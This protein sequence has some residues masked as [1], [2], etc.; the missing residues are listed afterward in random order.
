MFGAGLVLLA[1]AYQL[2]LQQRIIED[3][4]RRQ[5]GTWLREQ[6]QSPADT[7][8]LEP[9]GYIGFFSGLKMLDYP[10]LCSPEVVAARK[11]ASS[12]SY[13]F[14]WSEL[15]M[16][17]HPRWLVLRPYEATAIREREPLILERHYELARRFDV[18]EKVAAISFLPGRG[19]L[20]NDAVFEVYRRRDGWP[21]EA[22]LTPIG[23]RVLTRN[24]SWTGPAYDSGDNLAVHAPSVVEFVKPNRANSLSGGFGIFEG[25]YTE[26]IP[27]TDG[28]VFQV[29]FIDGQGKSQ[30]LFERTINPRT[31]PED[32]GLQPLRVELPEG[33]D[34]RIELSI[35]TGEAGNHEFDWTYWSR[36]ALETPRR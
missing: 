9:L 26:H 25:A 22:I 27:G 32:R 4:H 12:P 30:L 11:R 34:G 7:V 13:P 31:T 1:A 6:A 2:R 19:Y 23:A 14:C 18:A 5:I 33:I 20:V 21:T 8:F 15:I 24:Q 16:D 36:L 10:G 35:S 17:L 28:A 29:C 3:G